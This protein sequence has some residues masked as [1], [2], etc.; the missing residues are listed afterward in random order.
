MRT[1][2]FDEEALIRSA[3]RGDLEA[4]NQIALAYQDFL[5][6]TAVNILGDAD[7][8]ED[9]VQEALISAFRSLRSFRGSLLRGWLARVLVNACYDQLRRQRRH[10]V[11]PLDRADEYD[12]DMDAGPWLVDG[13]RLPHQQAEDHELQRLL[14]DG[15]QDLPPNYRAAEVLVDVEDLSYEEAAGILHVPVGTVKSRV[16]R[17]RMALRKTLAQHPALLPWGSQA[18]KVSL[19][20]YV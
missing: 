13:A 14:M 3:Q 5:F 6:R 17:A 18:A 11:I 9:A 1:I 15:L 10:P 7:A 12:N 4:F 16:A 20:D 8:A 19:E 2:P